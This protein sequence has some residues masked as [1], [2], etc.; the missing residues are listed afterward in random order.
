LRFRRNSD[1][2]QSA[3]PAQEDYVN[4]D[5]ARVATLRPASAIFIF[6]ALSGLIP[7]LARYGVISEWIL[8][9]HIIVGLAAIV[10]LTVIFIKHGRTANRDTPTRWWSAGL[11]SGIGWATLSLS[12]LWLVGPRARCRPELREMRAFRPCAAGSLR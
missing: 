4:N 11:W 9:L 8:L 2:C 3:Q 1:G 6:L 7:W 5:S 10:P 12:G